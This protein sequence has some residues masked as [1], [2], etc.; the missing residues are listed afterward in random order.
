[1]ALLCITVGFNGFQFNS[2]NCNHIDIAPN[3]AG[4]LM[5]ITNMS[6][7]TAGFLAPMVISFIIE[8]HVRNIFIFIR[9]PAP[10]TIINRGYYFNNSKYT[11]KHIKICI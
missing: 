3:F 9:D 4:T 5:G 7:N 8:D 11:Y 1:M 6:A 10:V 2:V